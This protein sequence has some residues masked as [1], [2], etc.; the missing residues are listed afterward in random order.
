VS[1]VCN[2]V[3]FATWLE[4]PILAPEADEFLPC[5]FGGQPFGFPVQRVVFWAM[6]LLYLPLILAM[7]GLMRSCLLRA[8]M[9]QAAG[10]QES[11]SSGCPVCG[12]RHCG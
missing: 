2:V 1:C 5:G 12:D 9:V 3:F 11:G 8:E 10:R 7:C 6:C 4:V